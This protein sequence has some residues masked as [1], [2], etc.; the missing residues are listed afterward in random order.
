MFQKLISKLLGHQPG[1]VRIRSGV[2][3]GLIFE[4]GRYIPGFEHGT[5]EAPVQ[6]VL[7]QH[8]REGQVFYDVGANVGFFTLIGASLVGKNGKVYAFEPVPTNAAAIRHNLA[9][10]DFGH[11]EV[12]EKA[13]SDHSGFEE[14]QVTHF[15]GGS[16]LVSAGKP[17]DV[18]T[19]L[20]VE[21][22]ALDAMLAT[23]LVQPPHM[24]KIDVEG[25]E[26][27]V[28]TGM[29]HILHTAKPIV[30]FE[31]DDA[32]AATAT[33]KYDAC[34]AF[35]NKQAYKVTRMENAY[36]EIP[37][38]VFHGVAFPAL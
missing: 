28:L 16:T 3:Q 33:Q 15:A 34:S 30:I 19:T 2:G 12:I 9:L 13:V 7:A 24:V 10:N 27:E 23:G 8:L 36:P 32:E 37:W 22:V 29:Q 18:S 17:A 26:L 21:L 38:H 25:A 14:L 6:A 4:A 31:V 20:S 1:P 35:L 11:V 5:S